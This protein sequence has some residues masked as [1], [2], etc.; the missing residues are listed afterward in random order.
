M[1]DIDWRGVARR[2][3]ELQKGQRGDPVRIWMDVRTNRARLEACSGP[4]DFQALLEEGRKV[5]R[6]YRC[7]VCNGELYREEW[8]W[9]Q[10]GL[11]H[12]QKHE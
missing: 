3:A 6:K 7:R 2:F 5:P 12:G 1:D 4:H 11:E 9:Y 10:E 8:L